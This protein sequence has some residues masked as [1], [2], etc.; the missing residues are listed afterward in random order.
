M[1]KDNQVDSSRFIPVG[2]IR[3][4]E[5]IDIQTNR[6]KVLLIE[7]NAGAAKT[8][9]LALRVGEALANGMAPECILILVFTETARDVMFRR[10][11]EIGVHHT[12][13]KQLKIQTF[14]DFSRDRLALIE[15]KGVASYPNIRQQFP[16]MLAAVD[17][18][19]VKYSESVENLQFS[20]NGL[21]LTQYL[22]AQLKLKANMVLCEE[23]SIDDL[24]TVFERYGV[25][26]A[27]FLVA[28][29][30]ERIRLGLR[31]QPNFRGSFD[32]TYDLARDINRDPDRF[33]EFSD[34]RLVIC[35]ELH[36]L[37][38][39]AF[40]IV[41]ALI[42]RPRC[43]FVGAGDCDQVIHATLGARH[44]YLS[45][46]FKERFIETQR[47]PLT[48]THRYGSHLAFC[49]QAFKGKP[50][51]SNVADKLEIKVETY[52]GGLEEGAK[53]VV[54][55]IKKWE[56]NGSGV[57]A[58]AV[59]IRDR[60]HSVVIENAL[61]AGGI[62][63][64]TP[65]MG[66]Y[67]QREE[68]L[69]LRGI[70]AIALRDFGAVKSKEVKE[71]IVEA[72]DLYGNLRIP[73]DELQAVKVGM[74]KHSQLHWFYEK[75]IQ[76]KDETKAPTVLD[77]TIRFVID[78]S[79]DA[80]AVDI[81]RKVCDRMHLKRIA[82]KLYVRQYDASVVIRSIEGFLSIAGEQTLSQFW[83]DLSAAEQFAIKYRDKDVL[84][85]DCVANSKGKEFDHVILPFVEVGE[86]PSPM[87]P[88]KDEEN[89]FYVGATRAKLRLTLVTPL[90][91]E[92]R[93]TFIKRMNITGT[94]AAANIAQTR[95]EN[96]FRVTPASRHYLR[97]SYSDKDRLKALGARWDQTRKKWYV[98][99]GMDLEA[100]AEWM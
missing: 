5:Q 94:N 28:V 79:P 92:K 66:S 89:L 45:T 65:P 37:N 73:P 29:E 11:I 56:R 83:S 87:F 91:G 36:D 77:S 82:E 41:C 35:D 86:Y 9:T 31:N 4:K 60:H 21:A 12:I 76:S 30:Y 51:E 46:R 10:L 48:I 38:E 68:I 8:T 98:P 44:E 72:L 55:S 15:D 84:T 99:I 81:L 53:C 42:D 18:A 16:P 69:F 25:T 100:F 1:P 32:S 7:A 2:I 34:Y 80:L 95:N 17:K 47:L 58:C 78:A 6:R 49:M 70:M 50:V 64:R 62:G 63:Y 39:A 59:L 88:L 26:E 27:E 67:L 90:D 93:S 23:F 71:S 97:S 52:T 74:A 20:T 75:Y 14:E 33:S 54:E 61:R 19:Y 13:V 57:D 96:I 40:R 43:F 22:D 3:T 85:L 24:S